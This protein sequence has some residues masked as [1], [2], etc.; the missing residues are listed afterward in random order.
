MRITAILITL[1]VGLGSATAGEKAG[2]T[3]PDTATV[4]GKHLVLNGMG[5]REA[6]WLNIDVYVA[7]L[8]LESRSSDAA[9]I[10]ASDQTKMLVLRF[11]RHVGR[12]DIVKAWAEGFEHNATVPLAQIQSGIDQLAA[13]MPRFSDGDTLIFSM[14][15]GQ[16]VE[17]VINGTRKGVIAGDDF[18]RSLLAIWLG[19]QPPTKAL[20]RG[21]LGQG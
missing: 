21:L 16:G 4:A 2:V 14:V 7:G 11:V 13:W 10:I 19:P 5:L 9:A 18:A 12:D 6:T 17:V 3:L 15:P 8:Y 1:L 20:K